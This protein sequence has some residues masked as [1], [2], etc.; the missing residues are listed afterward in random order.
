MNNF[1]TTHVQKFQQQ[2]RGNFT[3]LTTYFPGTATTTY[4]IPLQVFSGRFT[5][6]LHVI[7]LATSSKPHGL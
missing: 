3:P 6:R 7:Y 4:S 2:T 1:A 5:H